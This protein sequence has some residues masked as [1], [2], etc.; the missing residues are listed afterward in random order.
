MVTNRPPAQGHMDFVKSC[1]NTSKDDFS[2]NESFKSFIH[3]SVYNPLSFK[4]NLYRR[5]FI[6]HV[7]HK[8]SN[9]TFQTHKAV[10]FANKSSHAHY[11]AQ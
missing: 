9:Y 1:F 5:R 2:I 8:N 10:L 6:V 3:F 4:Y 7:R 11:D